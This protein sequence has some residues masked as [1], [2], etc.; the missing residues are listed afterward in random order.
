MTVPFLDLP[1]QYAGL[2]EE[3][4][5]HLDKVLDTSAY[6]LGPYA[7]QFEQAFAAFLGVRHVVGVANGTDALLLSL[8]ALGVGAGDEVI[9]AANSFVATAEAIAHAGAKPVFVDV[10]P[11]AQ[12]IDVGQVEAKISPRTKAI[13]PVHLYG[14]PADLGP[15]CELARSKGLAIVEDAAQAHGALY[16]GRTVGA[17][18]DAA[19]FSF[20]PGKNLGAYGDAGA[21]ATNRDDVAV[22]LRKLR[23]H[24]GVKKY[25][26][27]VV[28][29]N[30]R[31]D[32]LQAA[33]LLVKLARLNEWNRR[34]AEHASRYAELL[35]GATGIGLPV[36]RDRAT[37]VY[38]L[39]VIRVGASLRDGLRAYLQE[40][41]IAT[42]I[43]YP[44]PLH[45]TPAF[46]GLGYQPGDLPVSESLAHTILSLPMFPELRPE[47]IE[48]VAEQAARY[49][50]ERS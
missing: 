34:R 45:L 18:G 37:H 32:G 8:T 21:V 30:S 24:G 26:H 3:L 1:A 10:E 5:P 9:T 11:G 22:T 4:R 2:K 39:Y 20:Y 13:I 28:G 40:Q 48:Y 19:C 23:D 17:F 50:K 15:L 49:V 29:F 44:V 46:A 31:L 47:Q 7:E 25:E 41:G 6:I 12:T 27:E 33:V 14:Q 43:H 36:V 42:G 16:R 38:H 35:S